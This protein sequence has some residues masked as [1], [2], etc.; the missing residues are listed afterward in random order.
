MCM[1]L[2]SAASSISWV[3]AAAHAAN[4]LLSKYELGGTPSCTCQN[5]ALH[6]TDSNERL[7]TIQVTHSVLAAPDRRTEDVAESL[8][9]RT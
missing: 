9:R 3:P 8:S 2:L 5:R 4:M 7:Y 1:W 6:K